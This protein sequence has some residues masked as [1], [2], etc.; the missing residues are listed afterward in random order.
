MRKPTASCP[1]A[2]MMLALAANAVVLSAN[3]AFATGG[4][5]TAPSGNPF[6]VPGTQPGAPE[7]FT[8]SANGFATGAVVK[9]EICDGLNPASTAPAWDLSTDC[10]LGS[11]TAGQS[12]PGTSS[13]ITF[14]AGDANFGVV[15]FNGP[16]PQ[17]LFTCYTPTQWAT[18]N[19]GTV[20]P[21]TDL[22]AWNN[23]QIS[24]VDN[25][26]SAVLHDDLAE[27]LGLLR[28]C[29]QPSKQSPV[30]PRRAPGR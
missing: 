11:Q 18:A 8:I 21:T 25:V 20:D 26:R 4:T 13:T 14:P 17:S 16:S 15:P 9:V 1:L 29:R 22:P 6:K 2:V 30:P 19:N 27:P 28:G 10:D 7:S 3:T 5:I 12:S 23:C 24:H